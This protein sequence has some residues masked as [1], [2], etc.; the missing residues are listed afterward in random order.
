MSFGAHP[1]HPKM[2]RTRKPRSMIQLPVTSSACRARRTANRTLG[3]PISGEIVS[4]ERRGAMRGRTGPD[5]IAKE[6]ARVRTWPWLG[7]RI[8]R[9]AVVT[10]DCVAP[11]GDTESLPPTSGRVLQP[12]PALP[13]AKSPTQGAPPAG[14]MDPEAASLGKLA[15]CELFFAVARTPPSRWGG[16]SLLSLAERRDRRES[17]WAGTERVSVFMGLLFG[18]RSHEVS[19][20]F[21]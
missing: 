21:V 16:A 7:D 1:A 12:T 18:V 10:R 9:R 15:R 8:E 4:G 2:A 6:P 19:E 3:R 11:V 20:L 5:P 14:T 17:K 13:T